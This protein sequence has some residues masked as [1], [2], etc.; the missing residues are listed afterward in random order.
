MWA[1]C[2]IRTDLCEVVVFVMV[3]VLHCCDLVC[4]LSVH[5]RVLSPFKK[6]V[7]MQCVHVTMSWSDSVGTPHFSVVFVV[8]LCTIS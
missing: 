8:S 1:H 6:A 7:A 5:K 3:V 4:V 2:P